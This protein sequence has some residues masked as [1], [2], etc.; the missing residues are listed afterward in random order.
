MII[1][2]PGLLRAHPD[3]CCYLVC[4][5]DVHHEVALLGEGVLAEL[6]HVGPL[7]TVLL[8]VDLK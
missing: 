3:N 8:H 1:V 5:P 2:D 4:P 7:T 6:T